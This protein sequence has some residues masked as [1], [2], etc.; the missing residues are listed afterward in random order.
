MEGK[1]FLTSGCGGK[2]E[3]AKVY[4]Q[5]KWGRLQGGLVDQGAPI[6]TLVG[7]GVYRKKSR[8]GNGLELL[9]HVASGKEEGETHTRGLIVQLGR[10]EGKDGGEEKSPGL[11]KAQREIAPIKGGN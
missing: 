2:E 9:Q 6:T 3:L 5:G 8:K 4:P 1:V 10:T 11:G 7:R